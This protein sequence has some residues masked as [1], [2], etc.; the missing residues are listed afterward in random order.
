[1]VTLA[2]ESDHPYRCGIG[3]APLAEVANGVKYLPRDYLD[4]AGTQ[5]TMAMRQ[6]ASPLLTGEVPIRIAAD[7]LPEFVCFQRQPVPRKLPAF[8]GRSK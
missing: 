4:V 1:M 3:L 7:G 2:R 6:Y 8:V 5:I